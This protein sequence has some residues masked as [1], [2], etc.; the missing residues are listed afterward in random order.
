MLDDSYN[1][2]DGFTLIELLIVVAIIM[3]IGAIALPQYSEYRKRANDSAALAQIKEMVRAEEV[4]YTENGAY[5]TSLNALI[6]CGFTQ[7]MNVTR[8]R[9]LIDKTGTPSAVAYQLTATHKNGT[10]KV[11]LWMSDNGGLQ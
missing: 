9:T 7:D 5:T 6:Q 2:T 10:G 3:I 11:Y 8:T 4:Y 1:K